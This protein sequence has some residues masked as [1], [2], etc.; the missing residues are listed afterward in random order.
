M[1][2]S[3]SEL[4]VCNGG[5]SRQ[6]NQASNLYLHFTRKNLPFPTPGSELKNV[7]EPEFPF[8]SSKVLLCYFEDEES[9]PQNFLEA[10]RV[11]NPCSYENIPNLWCQKIGST[12][13]L[14]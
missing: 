4:A 14:R 11:K 3:P 10:P 1:T 12:I 7:T 8:R 5:G 13:Q 2:W 6:S 9:T